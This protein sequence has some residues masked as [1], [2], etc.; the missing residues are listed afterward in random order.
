MSNF[1]CLQ[2]SIVRLTLTNA[3]AIHVNMELSASMVMHSMSANAHLDG[4]VKPYSQ[5]K[6]ENTP[7]HCRHQL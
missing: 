2:V 5:V 1:Q 4:Q 6:I 7:F 3:K